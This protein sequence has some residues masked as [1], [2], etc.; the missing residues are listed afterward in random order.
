[1][2][3][4]GATKQEANKNGSTF[5][6]SWQRMEKMPLDPQARALLNEMGKTRDSLHLYT[7]D[8]ARKMYMA[9]RI[10]PKQLEPVKKI[11]NKAIFCL[12]HGIPV[13]IYTPLKGREPYPA[14]V[15]FHGGGFVFGN[16]DTHDSVCR[17]LANEAQCKVIS[18][19]YRLAPENPFPAA[20]EDAY[21]AVSWVYEN[22][23][24]E[25]IDAKRIAVG[26]DSAGGNLATVVC[27][28]AKEKKN[29]PLCFQLLFYPV[30]DFHMNTNSYEQFAEGYFLTK[31]LMAW[32]KKH[33][34][35]NEE[36]ANHILAS[37]FIANDVS[38]LPEA[39]IITAE[40]DPLRDEGEAY[41][42]KLK[43][44]NV[45]VELIRFAGM[46]HGFVGMKEQLDAGKR[47][48]AVAAQK[49]HDAFTKP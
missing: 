25:N 29:P 37:P 8:E 6:S 1:M 16:L 22:A 24:K 19:D 10:P 20:V 30:T 46:I 27:L 21:A 9:Q 18:V 45:P 7:P 28:L 42:K 44:A 34:L 47:A 40:Y 13:R 14:L 2:A 11:E 4:A 43:E 49:L 3:N 12:Q 35:P 39:L 17:S 36:D 23:Q 32:F 41:A 48:I 31:N 33:Y 5:I 15:Y 26:G 38:G